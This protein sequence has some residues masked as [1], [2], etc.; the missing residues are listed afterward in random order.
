MSTQPDEYRTKP[1]H[2]TEPISENLKEYLDLSPREFFCG[3]CN[4]KCTIGPDGERE[5]G[6]RRNPECKHALPR[7]DDPYSAPNENKSPIST[8][9][10]VC[11]ICHGEFDTTPSSDAKTC[12]PR[13][14]WDLGNSKR[15]Q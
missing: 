1:H 15:G 8:E 11:V 5:F 6:H 3:E 10:R 7:E 2:G 4:A 12:S 9:T 14:A 13:C